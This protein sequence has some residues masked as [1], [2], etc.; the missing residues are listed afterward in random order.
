[1]TLAV[2][3]EEET[4]TYATLKSDTFSSSHTQSSHAGLV[5]QHT[6]DRNVQNDVGGRNNGVAVANDHNRGNLNLDGDN[7]I[8]A[9]PGNAAAPPAP[10]PAPAPA[11]LPVVELP[12]VQWLQ[13]SL[14]AK[15]ALV[16]VLFTYNRRMDMERRLAVAA[17]ALFVYLLQIG[18]FLL[19][20]K[21]LVMRLVSCS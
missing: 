2:E 11:P 4:S 8:E 12:Q 19:W 14:V 18:A 6:S 9:N 17:A 5:V 13:W 15:L 7:N 21:I 1:M 20:F 16:C 3:G 10:A